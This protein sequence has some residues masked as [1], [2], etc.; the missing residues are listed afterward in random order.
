MR[1]D[2]HP[3]SPRLRLNR[4][5]PIFGTSTLDR[6]RLSWRTR[7]ACGPRSANPR[8]RRLYATS[9]A[10]G[11]PRRTAAT[12]GPGHTTPATGRSANRRQ[13][14]API[15][16]IQRGRSVVHHLHAHLIFATKYRRGMFDTKM[17]NLCEQVIAQVCANFEATSA[18]SNEA[19]DHLHQLVQYPPKVAPSHLLAPCRAS[20]PGSCDT[21]TSP[22]STRPPYATN[23]DLRP[24]PQPHAA[25]HHRPQSRTT[26]PTRNNPTRQGLLPALKDRISTPDHR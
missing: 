21:S 6:D 20:R 9:S 11:S 10:D 7:N 22:E 19:E 4:T 12:P 16:N 8:P 14:T 15:C 25:A 3:T 17:L 2:F 1:Y 5:Q 13:A 24:T 26:S 23:S 18:E